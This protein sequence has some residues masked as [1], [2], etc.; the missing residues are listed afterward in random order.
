[1]K[2]IQK[3]GDQLSRE[4]EILFD[5]KE[6]DHIVKILVNHPQIFIKFS[7]DFYYTITNERKLIQNIVFEY[8]DDNLENV[9]QRYY[10]E[11]KYISE[12]SIKVKFN[13]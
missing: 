2:R 3:V 4:F 9:I 10:K 11:K 7:K 8:I 13:K 12:H 6:N 5:I 1:M